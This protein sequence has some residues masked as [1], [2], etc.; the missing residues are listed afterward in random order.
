M[1]GIMPSDVS[2]AK[3]NCPHIHMTAANSWRFPWLWQLRLRRTSYMK[4]E[5]QRIEHEARDGDKRA[6]NVRNPRS[7]EAP[8]SPPSERIRSKAEDSHRKRK[9]ETERAVDVRILKCMAETVLYESFQ[10][11]PSACSASRR[12]V[13]APCPAPAGRAERSPPAL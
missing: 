11:T 4:N 1:G 7:A 2:C 10:F 9:I 6:V 12:G 5:G 13:L 8:M 3:E